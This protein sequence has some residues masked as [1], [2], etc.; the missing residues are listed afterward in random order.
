MAE[1]CFQG[2]ESGLGEGVEGGGGVLGGGAGEFGVVFMGEG[3]GA[4]AGAI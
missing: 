2:G 3:A 4:V 1:C